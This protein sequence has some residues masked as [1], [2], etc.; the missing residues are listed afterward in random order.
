MATGSSSDTGPEPGTP[1]VGVLR[2]AKV[3]TGG[4]GY[5][6]EVAGN[7]TGTGVEAPG[8]WLGTGAA[9]LGLRGEVHGDAL[10]AVLR[11]DD[12]LTLRRLGRSH[13]RVTVAGFD[14]S[15]CAPKSVSML[16]ALSPPEVAGE[17]LAAHERAV[18]AALDYV[19]RRAV[20]VRRPERGALV[21]VAAD[22]VAVAG[23]IHR[24]S[25]ALDPHLHS[26]VVM[27]NLG[28][29]PEG[30]FS[31]LD[32]RG[33]YAHTP[34]AGALYHAQLRHELT[35][36]LGVAWEPLRHGRGDIAGI[37]VE[38]R[39]AFS[40]RAAAIAEHLSARGL[41]GARASAIA[42]HATRPVRETQR[43]ADDLRPLWHDR[44]RALGLGPED[45]GAV[46]DRMPR[47]PGPGPDPALGERVVEELRQR[48]G[49]A[50]RR[51]VVRV[52][53]ATLGE[54]APAVA[55]EEAA[56]RL[57]GSL[58]LT[59]AHAGR[60][61]RGGVGER[62]HLVGGREL[63]PGRGELE[64]LLAA[65][66]MQMASGPERGLGRERSDDLGLGFG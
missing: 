31:A 64:R 58:P 55:V 2:V 9:A 14:L 18:D 8:R 15:F 30:R 32:G 27:A 29:G 35:T 39:R 52:W 51:D 61:E 62:R 25:R 53:S 20:A 40:Q 45:L 46:L 38:A 56:D 50:T 28:R 12:P 57:L 66:G 49:S 47:R 33:V 17:V 34:A 26:H 54:G 5:Y 24:V 41:G 13:D 22:A 21:P 36:R 37:G 43:S 16:H 23:F 7:G 65:R 48:G 1:E 6:L 11:G 42:G 19:E 59:P 4:H 63:T 10:G 44:A 60:V 3:R